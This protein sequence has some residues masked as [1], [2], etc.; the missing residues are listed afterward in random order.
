MLGSV[1]DW[2]GAANLLDVLEPVG[3]RFVTF[4]DFGIAE[5]IRDRPLWHRC[6]ED[7]WALLTN[8]CN[9]DGPD[10]LQATMND[11]WRP[12]RLPVLTIGSADRCHTDPRYAARLGVEIADILCGLHAGDGKFDQAPRQLVPREQPSAA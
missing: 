12:V 9:A 3:L 11:S 7:R 6:Q 8:N 2:I 1:S 4:A 5:N 10:S